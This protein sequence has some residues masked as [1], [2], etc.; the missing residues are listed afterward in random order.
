MVIFCNQAQINLVISILSIYLLGC[1]SSSEETSVI[2][3][4]TT[5][6][7]LVFRFDDPPSLLP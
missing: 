5:Y 6:C 3:G 4:I 1:R 7:S 2:L